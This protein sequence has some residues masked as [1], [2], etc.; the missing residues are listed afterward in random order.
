MVFCELLNHDDPWD[1]GPSNAQSSTG[2]SSGSGPTAPSAPKAKSTGWEIVPTRKR[3]KGLGRLEAAGGAS[4][5]IAACIVSGWAI[6]SGYL[7]R[8]GLAP[9]L[10]A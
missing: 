4:C 3:G 8:G 6:V 9:W 1:D 10:W 2:G 7:Q 5:I